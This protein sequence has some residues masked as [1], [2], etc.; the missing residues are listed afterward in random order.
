M[1][2]IPTHQRDGGE[3]NIEEY[4][5]SNNIEY[6]MTRENLKK[7]EK[8]IAAS[9]KNKVN[10]EKWKGKHKLILLESEDE[11]ELLATIVDIIKDVAA[12]KISVETQFKRFVDSRAKQ[13]RPK[14]VKTTNPLVDE[15]IV[16]L[17]STPP[18]SS[19]T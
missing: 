11:E 9:R 18:L 10:Q 4:I 12:N 8:E 6:A 19:P 13:G 3:E 1:I 7:I 14:K 17:V 15:E 16:D 5:E 2:T